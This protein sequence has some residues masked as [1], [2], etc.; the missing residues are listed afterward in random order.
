MKEKDGTPSIMTT[1]KDSYGLWL[2]PY[3]RRGAQVAVV[4]AATSVLAFNF[5]LASQPSPAASSTR[6][7]MATTDRQTVSPRPW[8]SPWVPHVPHDPHG[9]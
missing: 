6:V 7:T 4:L 1:I 5:A 2:K 8:V 9:Y 3:L